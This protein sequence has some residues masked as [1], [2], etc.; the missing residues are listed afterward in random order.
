MLG[1]I[2]QRLIQSIPL[3]FGATIIVF[4]VLRVIPG[5]DPAE[6]IL[7]PKESPEAYAAARKEFGLDKPLPIQ[8]VVWLKHIVQGDLGHSY[9]TKIPVTELLE[10]RIP[11]TLELT[12]AAMFI[13]IV[14]SVPA[15]ALAALNRGGKFDLF[16]T[17]MATVF[18]SV[19]GFWL[20]ILLIFV[21]SQHLHALP[22]AGRVDPFSSP[23]DA[24]KHLALPAATLAGYAIASMSRLVKTT[25]LE[26]IHEDYVRTARAKGLAGSVII[27]RHILP[28]AFVPVLTLMA[29]WFG[30]LL[31]GAVITE[32][33]F[34][35][36]GLGRLVLSSIQSRDYAVV[37]G[38]M[39][40]FV[41]I[42]ILINFMTDIA[43]GIID[44]RIRLGTQSRSAA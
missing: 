2:V 1:L 27:R 39:L 29:L 35:W 38:A 15:G 20:G 41:L 26:V 9:L 5:A 18:M 33:I 13:A 32:S 4:I 10:Q 12:F 22:P 40:Y 21:F 8:Y 16:M 25:V 44:P 31:G 6:L 36:P 23:V 17:W 19:P 37:Q 43:Y 11:A 42:F 14:V 3:V 30:R 34:A 28:N 7:G 24:I